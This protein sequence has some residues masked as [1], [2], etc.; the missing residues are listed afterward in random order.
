MLC[1]SQDEIDAEKSLSGGNN[2]SGS[3]NATDTSKT[4]ASH[5]HTDAVMSKIHASSQPQVQASTYKLD[6]FEGA[7]KDDA[8]IFHS[9]TS[10]REKQ[11]D[12]VLSGDN[13]E[14]RE[15][16]YSSGDLK[17][18]EVPRNLPQ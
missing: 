15:R 2:L 14:T 13:V 16:R 1:L 10:L 9:T 6:S 4:S 12:K 17:V 7:S 8:S 3:R 11:L 5:S 18:E